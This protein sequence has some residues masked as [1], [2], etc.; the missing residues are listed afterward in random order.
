M[1]TYI[2]NESKIF[3]LISFSDVK[4]YRYK[5]SAKPPIPK[6]D[7]KFQVWLLKVLENAQ[8]PFYRAKDINFD[9]IQLIVNDIEAPL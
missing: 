7:L 8:L 1:I 5:G 4:K 6:S 9:F 2:A 3:N